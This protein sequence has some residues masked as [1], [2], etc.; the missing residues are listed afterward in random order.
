MLDEPDV[1]PD[2]APRGSGTL[3]NK[4]IVIIGAGI[5]GLTA[6][7]AFARR[8]ANVHIYEQASALNEVGAGIQVTPNGSRVLAELGLSDAMDAASI[9]AQAVMPTDAISGKAIARFDLSSQVPPYRFFHRAALVEMIAQ[10]AQAAGVEI[11]FS[12]RVENID[13]DGTL[14]TNIGQISGDLCVGADGIHSVSRLLLGNTAEPEFTGQVAWRATIVAKDVEPVARIW[15]A[16]N[17]HV[18][19][20][21]LAKDTLNIVAVQ[22]RATWA[23]EGWKHGDDPDN[24]RA[25]FADTCPQLRDILGQVSETYLW[26]LFRHPVAKQWHNDRLVILGD[27]AHPTLP[28][29]AQ[30]ANL[31]IEDAYVL[32][33]C[34]DEADDLAT[35]LAR[36]QHERAL[37]VSRAIAAA[38]ANARNYHLSGLTRSLAHTGL[39]TLGF[40]AP[41]ALL[42]RLDWLYGFD[43]TK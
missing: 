24:L 29:L 20:Y 43:A 22:E 15:M 40:V 6:A 25:A 5:G 39:K 17:R 33:R 30:G 35:A 32:A 31:A 26:G 36:F 19:T 7:L 23:Q 34:C 4:R 37:R 13:K 27:A 11:S 3:R 14:N 28:F 9:V 2:D 8:G 21:P 10:G 12:V 1:M 41:D 16:P 18:V 38:N 42:K